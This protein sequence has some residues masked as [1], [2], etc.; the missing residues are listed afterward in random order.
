MKSLKAYL[1]F[2]AI[3]A[4]IAGTLLHF[5][6]EWSNFNPIIAFFVP[7]NESTWEH[8]KLLFFPMIIF[9]IFANIKL[10]KAYPCINSALAV[11][12]VVGTFLI[13]IIFYTYS[14]IFG[15]T[16]DALNISIFYISVAIAFY[17]SYK[18]A[19]SC[20]SEKYDTLLFAM[21]CAIALAFFIFTISP[22]DIPLF[23]SP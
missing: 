19:E 3:F 23:R 10:N 17:S 2:G 18:S 8:M 22:P 6:Y 4:S 9:S 14:G 13:P 11:G 21:L 15:F 7:V 16:L 5:A 20:A 12:T 1:I